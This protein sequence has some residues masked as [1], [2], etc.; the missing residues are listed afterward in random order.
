MP[1]DTKQTAAVAAALEQRGLGGLTVEEQFAVLPT[2]GPDMIISD[3]LGASLLVKPPWTW[4]NVT[5]AWV[6]SALVDL[7][8]PLVWSERLRRVH[9]EVADQLQSVGFQRVDD[10]E[11]PL[12]S[13]WRIEVA[14]PDDVALIVERLIT[15][16]PEPPSAGETVLKSR[17]AS[18][19]V[20]YVPG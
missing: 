8:V 5:G 17:E 1:E 13:D 4:R 16:P 10:G 18:S 9:D 2:G 3:T 11:D 6:L 7:S 14:G 20:R 19:P 15:E 12:S